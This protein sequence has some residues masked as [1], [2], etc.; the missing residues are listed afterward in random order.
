MT[1]HEI[2]FSKSKSV[3]LEEAFFTI[4]AK[5]NQLH[6]AVVAIPRGAL[7][8]AGEALAAN[9]SASTD[10]RVAL[11]MEYERNRPLRGFEAGEPL[12]PTKGDFFNIPIF[13]SHRY[14]NLLVVVSVEYKNRAAL[15]FKE[16][17]SFPHW[18]LWK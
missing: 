16:A 9:Y 13:C 10:I 2:L 12:V 15:P 5:F 7:T 6:C 1:Y 17:V 8:P 14:G 4:S 18:W 3:S 11:Q